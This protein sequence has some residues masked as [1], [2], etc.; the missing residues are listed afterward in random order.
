MRQIAKTIEY[1][2]RAIEII[3]DTYAVTPDEWGNGDLFLVYDHQDFFVERKGFDPTEIFESVS[4]SGKMEY[5]GY[6]VFPVFAYIHSGV[7]LSVGYEIGQ[8]RRSWDTSFKGF[9]LASKTDFTTREIGYDGA[10]ALCEEWNQYLSGDVYGYDTGTDSCW[11]YYGQEGMENAISDA[12]AN[13]DYDIQKG[14]H[15]HFAQLKKWIRSKTPLKYRREL[16]IH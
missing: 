5:D 4:E 16:S 2:G 15:Y 1:R 10:K 6:H 11:G 9:I 7:S 12:K 13:I 3:Y 8:Y 14:L